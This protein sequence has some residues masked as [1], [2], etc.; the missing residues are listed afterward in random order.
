M[1]DP[2]V[3]IAVPVPPARTVPIGV[4]IVVIGTMAIA[5]TAIIVMRADI[6]ADRWATSPTPAGAGPRR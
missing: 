2:L 1:N 4:A 3:P 5:I 6:D